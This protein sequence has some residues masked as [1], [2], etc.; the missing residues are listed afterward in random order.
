MTSHDDM[1]HSDDRSNES[2]IEEE[3]PA[4]KAL[5]ELLG[6]ISQEELARR[7][8]VSVVTVSRWERGVTPATFTVPQLKAFVAVL[9]SV[10]LD[11]DNLPDELTRPLV[12]SA[13][14]GGA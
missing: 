2:S 7:L 3:K 14:K 5:R 13:N 9:R 4:L 8:G 12:T 1:I 6:D 11:V 10:N